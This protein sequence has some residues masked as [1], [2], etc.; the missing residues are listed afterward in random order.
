MQDTMTDLFPASGNDTAQ[1]RN[2]A[3]I[4]LAEAINRARQQQDTQPD[5]AKD[6]KASALTRLRGLRHKLA[7]LYAAIPQDVELFDLGFI[8]EE[9]PRLFIDI[10]A[11]VEMSA[12]LA[13]YRFMQ[14]QRSGRSVILETDDEAIL[15]A[16]ITDYIAR[17]LIDRE[18]AMETDARTAS[19]VTAMSPS[20]SSMPHPRPEPSMTAAEAFRQWSSAGKSAASSTLAEGAAPASPSPAAVAP[21]ALP[22]MRQDDDHPARAAATTAIESAASSISEAAQAIRAREASAA[23]LLAPAPAAVIPAVQSV[24]VAAA[25][26]SNAWWLW[27]LIALLMGVGLG[28]AALYAYAASLIR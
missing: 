13:Q 15:I 25:P 21:A 10:I 27:P 18:K 5:L 8:T 9:K 11:F 1:S 20:V 16:G 4:A 17:R 7:P 24:A 2:L 14:E 22:V 3:A 26:R 6:I 19:G 23:V 28:I 12:D